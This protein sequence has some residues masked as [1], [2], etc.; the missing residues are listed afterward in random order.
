MGPGGCQKPGEAGPRVVN[1]RIETHELLRGAP[2]EGRPFEFKARLYAVG[3]AAESEI[4]ERIARCGRITF[5]EFMQTALYHPAGG[6]YAREN[7]EGPHG[8]YFTSPAAHPAFGALISLHLVRM[9]EALD[10]PSPFYA[11]E[12]GAG[13]GLLARDVVAYARNLPHPFGDALRYLA[14][15][16][17]PA[18][19]LPD[20]PH[21]TYQRIAASG[22]PA[23]GIVGCILSNE[24]VDSF[25]VHRF[26]V[27][28]G[29]LKELFVSIE[30]GRYVEVLDEPSTPHLEGRLKDLGLRV[31][32]GYRSE[33]NLQI[34]PWMTEVADALE[35][36][37]V[38]TIDY[39]HTAQDLYSRERSAG[40]LQT[41][42]HHT[43]ASSPYERI[44]G[45]DLTSHVDFTA[46]ASVG[47]AAGL[48]A[49][50][51]ATQADYLRGLGID[52]W[53]RRLRTQGLPQ[54][55]LDSNALGMRELVRLEGLGGFK[56]LVQEK[57][58]GNADLGRVA[59]LNAPAEE[60]KSPAADLPTPMLRPEH[61]PLMEG[62]YPHA[63]WEPEHPWPPQ[64]SQP[65]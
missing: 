61:A 41:Y 50:R 22:T 64:S 43:Q 65:A 32:E 27:Q 24:L 28:G 36:G 58:L 31:P 34:G 35:R 12:M 47:E 5:A 10:R 33:V 56:V 9:W 19:T 63:A 16:R 52:T 48:R 37:F 44:G 42:Y 51:L 54:R 7:P 6:Y 2:T 49:V 23:R 8:D 45:Q 17:S 62:R 55:D 15:D 38:L 3:T 25:P 26:Q 4:R 40:T 21:P 18:P 59:P 60:G 13:S 1:I 14:L 20:G 57:G 39:G 53:L 46:V 30:D 29:A 11:V